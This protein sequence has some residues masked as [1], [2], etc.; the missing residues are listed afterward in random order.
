MERSKRRGAPSTEGSN[1]SS[2]SRLRAAPGSGEPGLRYARV[3]DVLLTYLSVTL[4]DATLERALRSRRLTA[5]T[6]SEAE[7]QELASD[8]M[9]GLRLFVPEEKL[10]KLM[11]DLADV[12]DLQP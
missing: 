8:I 11:L 7:L 9:V 2:H 5:D 6:I 3:R 10:S 1:L 12:L 4:V